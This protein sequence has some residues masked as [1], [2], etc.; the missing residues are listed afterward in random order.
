MKLFIPLLMLIGYSAIGFS[1]KKDSTW[2]G[3]VSGIVRDSAHNYTLPGATLAVYIQKDSS[4]VSYQLS[5]N[6]GEFHF[7]QLPVN[8]PLRIV[9][10]YMG[11]RSAAKKFIITGETIDLK[12]ICLDRKDND[13][14]E[15]EVIAVP[16]VQMNGDTLE[17]NADAFKLDPNAQTEDLLRVLPGV[18]L[19]GDGTITINGKEVRSVLVDGKPFLGGDKRIATQ[20][21]PKD[22]VDKIQVYQQNKNRDNP[23]DSVTEV[24]IKLKANKKVGHFG[25]VAAGYGTSQHFEADGSLSFFSPTTQIG[26]VGASNNINKTGDDVTELLRNSTFKGVGNSTAYQSDFSMQGINQPNSGG[27]VLQHDFISDPDYM[28]ENRLTATYF[29]KNNITDLLRNTQTTTSLGG[30]STLLQRDNNDSRL[31]NTQQNF[32]ARYNKHEDDK[33]SYIRAGFNTSNSRNNTSNESSVFNG[34]RELQSTNNTANENNN[35][36]NNVSL[37]AGMSKISSGDRPGGYDISYSLNAGNNHNNRRQQTSFAS[38][39]DPSQ[40]KQFDRTY[41]TSSNDTRQTLLL[42]SGNLTPWMISGYHQISLFKMQLKNDLTVSTQSE[43]NEVADKDTAKGNY[44]LNRYLTNK[45]NYTIVDEQPAL[46]FSRNFMKGLVNR[47]SKN[48][49]VEVNAQL[50]FYN[51]QNHSD[52]DFQNISRRYRKFVP[53]ASVQY[54]NSQYGDYYDTYR[55]SFLTSSQYPGIMQLVPLVD[56]SNLYYIRGGNAA[57]KSADKRELSFYMQHSS[58][59]AKNVFNYGLNA[60]AGIINNSFA[61][62]SMTDSLGRSSHYTV[63]ADGNRYLSGSGNLSKAFKLG[64]QQLQITTFV[65]LNLSRTP[66]NIGGVWNRSNNFNNVNSLRLFYTYSDILTLSLIQEFSYYHSKQEGIDGNELS[67][68]SRESNVS[69][70]INCTK[71]FSVSSNIAWRHNAATG[72]GPID[73]TIWNANATYRFMKS[74]NFELK[75]SAMDLLHQNTSIITYGTGNVL[76]YGTANVLQQY[77]MCT[78]AWFPRKFGKKERE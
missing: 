23:L 24:N 55:I 14:K 77:F 74:N 2:K 57:L 50:Q 69:G 19:W 71:K 48:V 51:Q 37:S 44:L 30:D 35:D 52:R 8:L 1:Q 36:Q 20:N 28:K 53:S 76:T 56:S 26:F 66:N 33:L 45:Y 59:R 6:F 64:A 31:A 32:D 65:S 22:A 42:R 27:F 21:I 4:L 38:I 49:L 67:N 12:E 13:L 72:S 15:V 34:E 54:I 61:D 43:N 73:F 40:N 9:V 3:A 63:N 60:T 10:S 47:Y 68:R 25:K 18:T 41:N 75:L 62:S 58:V 46:N 11:Y 17:F 16:P 39:A 78:V 7:K 29:L 70:S 5:N